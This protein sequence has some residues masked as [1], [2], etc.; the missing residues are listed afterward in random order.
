MT[1]IKAAC[2]FVSQ[3]R[4]GVTLAASPENRP[5][6]D[7]EAGQP[8]TAEKKKKPTL[9]RAEQSEAGRVPRSRLTTHFFILSP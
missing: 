3:G 6:L 9:G 4:E 7:S 8:G 1:N 2:L 5:S